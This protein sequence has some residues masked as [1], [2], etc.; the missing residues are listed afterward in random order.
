[1]LFYRETLSEI[2]EMAGD[3]VAEARAELEQGSRFP[4]FFCR[5]RKCGAAIHAG[6]RTLA[7]SARVRARREVIRS[8]LLRSLETR[9]GNRRLQGSKI[10][11]ATIS[12]INGAPGKRR[13]HMCSLYVLIRATANPKGGEAQ[14]PPL[15]RRYQYGRRRTARSACSSYGLRRLIEPL[16]RAGP[17][18]PQPFPVAAPVSG[19]L[20]LRPAL[21]ISWRYQRRRPFD[22]HEDDVFASAWLIPRGIEGEQF[23]EPW[24]RVKDRGQSLEA[25]ALPGQWIDDVDLDRRVLPQVRDGRR[26]TDISKDQ[27]IL[28][29]HGGCPLRR[30]IGRAVGAHSGN[31]SELLLLDRPPHISR[32]NAHRC[33]VFNVE[34]SATSEARSAFNA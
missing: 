28:V 2:G 7:C 15:A 11:S 16:R 13:L 9:L 10:G 22:L 33:P 34:N 23:V 4:E 27:V 3:P 32:E 31:K 5:E 25:V 24:A 8:N 18:I 1:M 20:R 30:E 21:I 6:Y 17:P 26:R 29:P 19:Y 14:A 12:S